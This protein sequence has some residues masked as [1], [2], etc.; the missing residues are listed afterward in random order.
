MIQLDFCE[1]FISL[2]QENEDV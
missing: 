2:Q 1:N